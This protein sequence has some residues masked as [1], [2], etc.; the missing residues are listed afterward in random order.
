MQRNRLPGPRAIAAFRVPSLPSGR[1]SLAPVAPRASC[2]AAHPAGRPAAPGGSDGILACLAALPG[3]PIPRE[4]LLGLPA[5]IFAGNF[6]Y[7]P[8]PPAPP[9]CP[10]KD[11]FAGWRI[12]QGLVDVRRLLHPRRLQGL[13]QLSSARLQIAHLIDIRL[14][15]LGGFEEAAFFLGGQLHRQGE[16]K[17]PE[18]GLQWNVADSTNLAAFSI[19]VRACRFSPDPA[20]ADENNASRPS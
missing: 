10:E 3:P 1:G 11:H 9:S 15:Y 12:R 17:G 14:G 16:Q 5:G 2:A 20:S 19:R 18:L 6:L 13:L 4:R 8:A 7:A